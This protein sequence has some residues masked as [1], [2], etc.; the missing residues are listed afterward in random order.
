MNIDMFDTLSSS[1]SSRVGSPLN[2]TT[3]IS[4]RAP[5]SPA[6]LKAVPLSAITTTT[7]TN[8]TAPPLDRASSPSSSGKRKSLNRGPRIPFTAGQVA[9]LEAKFAATQ[10][11]SSMEVCHLAK[12]LNLTDTRVS[13]LVGLF[14]DLIKLEN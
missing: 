14:V 13:W 8:T 1:I 3:T 2:E 5:T 10:Y 7:T 6:P 9:E 11:L 4:I 12:R